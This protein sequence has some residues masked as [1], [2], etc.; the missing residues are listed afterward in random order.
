[1]DS[2]RHVSQLEAGVLE[3]ADWLSKLLPGLHILTRHINAELCTSNTATCN[4][5]QD[6]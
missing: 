1:M 4:V 2:S 3:G 6:A 5:I